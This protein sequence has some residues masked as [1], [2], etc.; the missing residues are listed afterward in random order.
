MADYIQH[1]TAR[2]RLGYTGPLGDHKFTVRLTDEV[3]DR[4]IIV[5]EATAALLRPLLSRNTQITRAD[6]ALRGTNTFLPVQFAPVAGTG[7]FDINAGYPGGYQ[8]YVSGRGAD[9][10]KA[11]ITF[12]YGQ[13]LFNNRMSVP[14]SGYNPALVNLVNGLQDPAVYV[15]I[16]RKPVQ[17]ADI[18]RLGINDA[19]TRK[20]R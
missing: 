6:L 5:A 19:V 10:G 12:F 16:D 4:V 15:A 8:V 2:L 9:G 3:L 20:L 14:I 18:A 7:A 13:L 17:Y 11:A 1:Y